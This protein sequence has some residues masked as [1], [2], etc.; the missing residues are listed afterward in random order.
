[1]AIS[2][3]PYS[4]A[5]IP[6]GVN[7]SSRSFHIASDSLVFRS[8]EPD[9]HKVT[10]RRFFPRL[11]R[12]FDNLPQ[13]YSFEGANLHILLVRL[14][15]Q[16]SHRAP[17]TYRTALTD[18]H[19]HTLFAHNSFS[20]IGRPKL[21]IRLF[22]PT[23]IIVLCCDL[24]AS[25]GKFALGLCHLPRNQIRI[26]LP[27]SPTVVGCT[28]ASAYQK[29]VLTSATTATKTFLFLNHHNLYS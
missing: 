8:E 29:S 6:I 4:R 23:T 22:H 28:H 17:R 1:V 21:R 14:V 19:S 26:R 25:M 7:I 11:T 9:T 2:G 12:P 27:D 3:S 16:P 5:A 15:S 24:I 20:E 10:P 18:S 13:P